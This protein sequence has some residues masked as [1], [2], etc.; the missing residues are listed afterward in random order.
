MA[1][2]SPSIKEYF[3]SC[4]RNVSAYG[5]SIVDK[6]FLFF[7]FATMVYNSPFLVLIN[8]NLE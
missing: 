6:Y 8:A 2:H 5:Y 7:V 4:L 3:F 1:L